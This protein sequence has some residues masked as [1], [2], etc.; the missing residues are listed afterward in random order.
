MSPLLNGPRGWAAALVALSCSMPWPATAADEVPRAADPAVEELVVRDVAPLPGGAIDRDLLVANPQYASG[1]QIVR[2]QTIGLAG[3]LEQQ[4]GA[5][6]LSEAQSNVLQPDLW[7]R[8]YVASPLLGVPQGV[9]VYQ[10]GVRVNETFGDTVNWD[11]LPEIAIAEVELIPG[12]DPLFG[13][14]ALGGAITMRTK[15]G[16]SSPVTGGRVTGG[17]FGR[18][19]I[20]AESGWNDGRFG[21]YLGVHYLDEAGW[22]DQSPS[23]AV[24]VF[25]S[26]GWRGASSGIDL[27]LGFADTDLTGNGAT[28][29]ALMEMDRAAVFTFP[30]T[31][32]NR[33]QSYALE[34]THRFTE[35]WSITS[36]GYY[37]GLD[38]KTLNGDSTEFTPC[39]LPEHAGLLCEDEDVG[40]PDE[41]VVV[42]Q[43]GDPAMD[44]LDAVNNRTAT[45]Q[46]S[47]GFTAQARFDHEIAGL[48]G[49]LVGGFGY[50]GGRADFDST[51]EL[52]RLTDER[53]TTSTG[54]FVPAADVAVRADRDVWSVYAT[55]VL[56]LTP[57]LTFNAGARF[58]STS[59]DLRDQSGLAPDL[60]GSHDYARVNPVVG[61]RY[62]VVDELTVFGAYRES[63]RTPSPVELACADPE[64]PC[65]LPNAFLADPPLDQVVARTGEIGLRGAV[66]P[67]VDRATLSLFWTRNADDI[68]F[69]ST[70]GVTSNEGFFDNV[71][72]TLRRGLELGLFGS[73]D[74]MELEWR[75]DYSYVLATFDD[76]FAVSS[77]NHPNANADG[78]ID[79][80]AGDRIPSIPEHI[81]KAGLDW[82]PARDLRVGVDLRFYSDRY[83][84]GDEANLLDPIHPYAIVGLRGE[85]RVWR[86][87]SLL[88]RFDNLF[89]S[90]YE[91]FGLLGDPEEVLGP[92]FDDPRFLSPGAPIGGWVGASVWF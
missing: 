9:A 35:A 84:R 43:S 57:E 26:L 51:V 59:I 27:D 68:L 42:D 8:G 74:V 5:V 46:S 2:S 54:R 38:T 22:R 52:A 49:T 4:M 12:A 36:F 19:A 48:T 88:A 91:T 31:T 47:Y 79:V 29:I 86:N 89:D 30:D 14:N 40:T 20:D 62:R 18:V 10:N 66:A 64:A 34:G 90:N 81:L 25:G 67:Y 21:Y 3:F 39:E 23:A 11:L 33:L 1:E 55:E 32:K 63:S 41:E 65:N 13:L 85:W 61:L 78:D 7:Y 17:S 28:P 37:R 75:L 24:N 92:E 45:D 16:F 70:G 72:D 58:L 44:D 77:P 6:A 83:L 69:V 53:G 71:G 15:D 73:I 60:N 82:S 56:S 50:D 76:S 80:R 87:V